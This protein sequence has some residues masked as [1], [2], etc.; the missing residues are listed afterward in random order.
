MFVEA[1]ADVNIKNNIGRTALMEASNSAYG[2]DKV[3]QVLINAGAGLNAIDNNCWTSLMFACKTILDIRIIRLLLENYADPNIQNNDGDTALIIA[4]GRGSENVCKLLLDFYANI[5]VANNSGVRF[6]D[7]IDRKM[8]SMYSDYIEHKFFVNGCKKMVYN[9]VLVNIPIW[10]KMV[11][12][13]PD[14]FGY[15]IT[16]YDFTKEIDVN[17]LDYLSV[18]ENNLPDKVGEYLALY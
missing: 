17:V 6:R 10:N 9:L 3:V 4:S 13:K 8:I 12:F 2:S 11:R 7:N 1:G 15:K 14:N 18:D 5:D 16:R